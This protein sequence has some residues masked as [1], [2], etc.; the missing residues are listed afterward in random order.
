MKVRFPG[1]GQLLELN[2]LWET[3]DDRHEAVLGALRAGAV[4]RDDFKRL[5]DDYTAARRAYEELGSSIPEIEM[6]D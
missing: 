6:H 1:P 3:M 4:P 5:W 2:E